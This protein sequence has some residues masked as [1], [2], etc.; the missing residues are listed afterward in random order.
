MNHLLAYT[1][2]ARSTYYAV[3]K[4]LR[5]GDKYA[6]IR[7]ELRDLY[8]HHKGRYGYRRMTYALRAKGHT[9]NHKVVL[10]LMQEDGLTSKV[11]LKKYRSYRGTEGRIV[12]N[13]LRRNFTASAPYQK[14]ATDITEFH[15]FGRKV[16]LSTMQDMYNGEI[17]AYEVSERPILQQVMTMLEK[18]VTSIPTLAGCILH[19][20]QGWQYQHRT[21]QQWLIDHHIRQSMSR[22]G[23]CLDN[24]VMEN[25]FGILK[26]ELFY[27]QEFT[28]YDH[29]IAELHSYITYYN[30]QRI[31]C[32]LKGMSPV[33]YRIHALQIA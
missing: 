7:Q 4:R 30:T 5:K 11:R 23:N 13:L 6:C 21:Y 14:V 22:K 24:A 2:M 26:S 33:K 25:F 19:S 32:K 20:D 12:P 10:R 17:L 3:C 8:D 1:K 31:Q 18:A 27:L 16:Y 15:L 28:S 29:F 9:I